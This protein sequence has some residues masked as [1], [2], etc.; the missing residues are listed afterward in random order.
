[1]AGGNDTEAAAEFLYTKLAAAAG[2]T[3]LTIYDGG[4]PASATLPFVSFEWYPSFGIT[5]SATGNYVLSRPHYRIKIHA[6][7][8]P[9]SALAT[10]K[11]AA[12]DAV[13]QKTATT[14]HGQTLGAVVVD[15][16][17]EE[18]EQAGVTFRRL[19]IEV[20][21]TVRSNP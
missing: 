13:H 5:N 20:E 16:F 3:G 2:L 18:E 1:M 15:E 4:A 19:G 17:K 6:K 11:K 14:S 7:E 21:I 8:Q 12:Y 9:F 10:Y